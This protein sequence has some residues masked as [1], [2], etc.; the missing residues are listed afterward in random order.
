MVFV[1]D[2]TFSMTEI[3]HAIQARFEDSGGPSSF[4]T[5]TFPLILSEFEKNEY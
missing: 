2:S 4:F 3:A 1:R 5:G